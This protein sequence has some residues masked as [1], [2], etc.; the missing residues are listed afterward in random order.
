MPT[1]AFIYS[2]AMTESKGDVPKEGAQRQSKQQKCIKNRL[3]AVEVI[4]GPV[5]LM[6][7]VS[8]DNTMAG[9][10]NLAIEI[11]RVGLE[12]L[13]KELEVKGLR[14]PRTLHFQFDNCGENKVHN[15][16]INHI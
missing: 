12:Y 3:F 5:N 1:D 8:V 15:L 4:C 9:G 14:M 11:Q 10:A 7:Y 13:T 16:I 6:L 2:D